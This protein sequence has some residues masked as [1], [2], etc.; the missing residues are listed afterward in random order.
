[1]V[2]TFF[3]TKNSAIKIPIWQIICQPLISLCCFSK[4]CKS[5]SVYKNQKFID[6]GQEIL[7]ANLNIETIIKQLNNH[8]KIIKKYINDHEIIDENETFILSDSDEVDPERS[9]NH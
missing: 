4:C 5:C 2:E 6:S 8:E 7:E 3:K 9:E 1:M